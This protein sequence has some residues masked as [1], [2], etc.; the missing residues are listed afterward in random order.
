[1][2]KPDIDILIRRHVP[3]AGV[4]AWHTL[5]I[6][7]GLRSG[8]LFVNL[9]LVQLAKRP[10]QLPQA[11]VVGRVGPDLSIPARADFLSAVDY[12]KIPCLCHDPEASILSSI[13]DSRS[14]RI[15]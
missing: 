4:T 14:K 1:L 15:A 13:V 12:K 6:S 9:V 11:E 5:M 10:S 7:A 8:R 3:V 2:K